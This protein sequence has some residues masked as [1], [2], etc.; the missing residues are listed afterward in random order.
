M[1]NKIFIFL[2]MI[3]LHI[4]DDYTLQG[5]LANMK[6]KSWW[7]EQT[8]SILYKYDYVWAL[9]MHS[10]SW[11]FMIT[12]PIMYLFKFE[13]NIEF[14]TLFIVNMIIHAVVDHVKA[15][16][17]CIN[18]W[19]DQIIHILQIIWLFTKFVLN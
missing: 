7:L 8:N 12:L 19:E 3:F 17:K 6:Q 9:I 11:T 4:V 18:L 14:L 15:N 5:I 1:T 16:M 2:L 10:F 13:L